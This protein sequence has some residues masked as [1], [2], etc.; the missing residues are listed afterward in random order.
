ME[1]GTTSGASRLLRVGVA[2][3]VVVG[4]AGALAGCAFVDTRLNPPKY[5]QPDDGP[6]ARVRVVAAQGN[7]QVQPGTQCVRPPFEGAGSVGTP[8]MGGPRA[9][10]LGMPKPADLRHRSE[11]YARAGEPLLVHVNVPASG[12]GCPSAPPSGSG[13]R[14]ICTP[15]PIVAGCHTALTFVP[16]ADVDYQITLQ[17]FAGR[18]SA[19]LEV[20]EQDESDRIRMR[21]IPGTEAQPCTGNTIGDD[22]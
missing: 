10:D 19:W 21:S 15:A 16:D 9:W 18:C 17:R 1:V 13:I 8:A 4:S 5:V 2:V 7:V 22:T 20:I 14:T 3:A 6:R 11:I 12:G